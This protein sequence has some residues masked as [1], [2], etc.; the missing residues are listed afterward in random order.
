MHREIF[1]NLNASYG[2]FTLDVA[3]DS[4]GYNAQCFSYC[5]PNKSFLTTAATH[6]RVWC[7]PPFPHAANFLQHY[8]DCKAKSPTT[9]SAMFVL[10]QWLTAAWLP[11][12]ST[13][14][15]IPHTGWLLYTMTPWQ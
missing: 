8:L 12:T 1:Y 10:P 11:L 4:N 15:A 2:P 13:F 7:N 9:T 14:R 3:A 6:H 5:S